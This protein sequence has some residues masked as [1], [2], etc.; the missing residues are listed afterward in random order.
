MSVIYKSIKFF[1][2]WLYINI[3]KWD[4]AVADRVPV[5]N[6]AGAKVMVGAVQAVV[7]A[8]MSLTG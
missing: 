6:R 3:F 7:T 2:R 4:V 5:A 8:S 1:A